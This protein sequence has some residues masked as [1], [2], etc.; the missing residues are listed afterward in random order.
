MKTTKLEMPFGY[1]ALNNAAKLLFKLGFPILR[2]DEETVSKIAIKQSRL[3]DF[4]DPNY[5]EGLQIL[6]DSLEEAKL[7]PLGRFM[8]KDMITTYLTQRL[9]L[10]ESRKTEAK[11]YDQPLTPPL[12]ITGLARSGTTFLQRMLAFDHTHRALPQ[13]LLMRPFPKSG[14]ENNSSPDWRL[15]E[16]EKAWSFMQPLLPGLDA[17]HY[18]RADTPEECILA[19]GLTFDSLIF[20]TLFPVFSYMDWYLEERDNYQKYLEYRWLLQVFQSQEPEQRLVL[21]APAHTGNLKQIKKAVPE[22][23]VIQTHRDPVACV[24]SVCSLTYTFYRAVTNQ[25][26]MQRITDRT[27][28]LYESWL[29]RSIAYRESHPNSVLDIFFK[30]LVSDP[31][32]TVRN[33]YTHFDLPLSKSNEANL[34]N[35]IQENPK[36]KHGKH[37]YTAADY[38]LVESEIANRFQFYTDYFGPSNFL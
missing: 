31:I 28:S 20:G 34:K 29:K 17:I 15:K 9:L 12:M 25:I 10:T 38:G 16:M 30:D 1:K 33:V 27:L 21:K 36:N 19:L 24:I 35:F 3:T 32:G 11:I 4:G 14:E 26:D 6:I 23:L 2:L 8:A 13:W 18:A 7:H 5:R 37:R 22:A